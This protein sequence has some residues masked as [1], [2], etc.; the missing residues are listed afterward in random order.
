MIKTVQL[1]KQYGR[2][3]ALDALNLQVEKG[4]LFGFIGPNGA[5][6]TT[7]LRLLAG[8]L[9]PSS[10]QIWFDGQ[11][12]S[13]DPDQARWQI[14]YMPDFFGVYEDMKV[15]EYLDFFA[16]CYHL[17]PD[18]RRRVV[19]ELLELVDLTHKRDA[20]VE[21]L[22]RG[23]RQRLCLAHALVHDPHILLLD[24]PASGLDP[25]A[26]IEM[27][28]LLK[29]LS[30]LGKTIIISS[31]ILAELAEMCDHIGVIEKG[32]LLYNGPVQRLNRQLHSQRQVRLRTLSPDATVETALKSYPGVIDALPSKNG[33][34]FGLNGDDDSLAGLLAHLVNHAVRITHFSET[35]SDLESVFMQITTGDVE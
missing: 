14:G 21:S 23:M 10:G 26:R 25:R 7:T 30:S 35:S 34:E 17:A 6:K 32:R 20:W 9:E 31:H 11:D 22:S 16:R 13:R 28:E 1:T 33:W 29:E 5:G 18:R 4:S 27:R 2:L 12:I 8:L 3:T 19:D 15:W 24:E